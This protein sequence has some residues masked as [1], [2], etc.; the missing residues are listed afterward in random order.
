MKL[1]W[2]RGVDSKPEGK[3]NQTKTK[4]TNQHHG[5]KNRGQCNNCSASLL[6]LEGSAAPNAQ[7]PKEQ[8][9]YVRE[10]CVCILESE[11]EAEENSKDQSGAREEGR[12]LLGAMLRKPEARGKCSWG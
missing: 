3:K 2:L 1:G 10:P 11:A 12:E 4:T 6:E 7:G 8:A 9:L 5:H